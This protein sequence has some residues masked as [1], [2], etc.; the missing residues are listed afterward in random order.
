LK[1]LN[2]F[3]ENDN[4]F[5]RY[6]NYITDDVID[7]VR[8]QNLNQD[9]QSSYNLPLEVYQNMAVNVLNFYLAKK[10]YMIFRDNSLFDKSQAVKTRL[11]LSYKSNFGND[12]LF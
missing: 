12:L 9:V 4:F 7:Y 11:I 5:T 1:N 2:I 3:S 8:L 10:G 6:L